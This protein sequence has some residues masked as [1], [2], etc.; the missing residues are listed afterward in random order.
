MNVNDKLLREVVALRA[1]GHCE[2]P[3]CSITDCDPHHVGG[4]SN[5][6]IYDP[7]TC[8]NLCCGHHNGNTISAHLSPEIFKQLIIAHGVRSR[9]WFDEVSRK[10]NQT[11][12]DTPEF[13]AACK[14]KLQSELRRLAA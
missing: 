13:R 9:E 10:K 2:Y 5:F 11:Q 1:G 12:K 4:R 7:D 14:E 8:I 3:G 6:V